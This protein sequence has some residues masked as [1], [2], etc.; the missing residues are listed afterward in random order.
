[1]WAL[2]LLRRNSHIT[3]TA[4]TARAGGDGG[5]I[6]LNTAAIAAFPGENSDITANAF[7]GAGGRIEIS[8]DGIF[9]LGELTREDLQEQ[10]G[11]PELTQI[12]N[13]S[14]QLESNDIVAISQADANLSGQIVFNTP[15]VDS[16]Q[17]IVELPE[18]IVDPEE[19]VSENPCAQ[20]ERSE[21][22]D[23]GR[24]GLPANPEQLGTRGA[25]QVEWIAPVFPETAGV[26]LQKRPSPTVET[27]V[28]ARGWV[29]QENGKVK[30][31][32]RATAEV[33][34]TS[35]LEVVP[36]NCTRP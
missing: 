25:T 4:G 27:I 7:E 10:F 29:L 26:R 24:G 36:V 6:T 23:L 1:M 21:F 17:G 8:A 11:T 33:G 13:P 15:D 5:N 12:E 14:Q 30:L 2:L 18:N 32:D 3:T 19:L 22:V 34:R 28:P 16:T 35:R 9:G 31:I 20:G